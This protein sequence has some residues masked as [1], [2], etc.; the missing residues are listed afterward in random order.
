MPRN[1]AEDIVSSISQ[2]QQQDELGAPSP[3]N[4]KNVHQMEVKRGM[5][6]VANGQDEE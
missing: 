4:V 2:T 6:L 5:E 1:R 3:Q